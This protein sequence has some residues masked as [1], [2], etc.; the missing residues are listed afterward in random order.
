MRSASSFSFSYLNAR[1]GK[2]GCGFLGYPFCRRDHN[3]LDLHSEKSV[4]NGKGLPPG[5]LGI[6]HV[7]RILRA[8]STMRRSGRQRQLIAVSRAKSLAL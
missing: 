8:E 2:S 6:V 5:S 4:F 1:P 7:I 3:V